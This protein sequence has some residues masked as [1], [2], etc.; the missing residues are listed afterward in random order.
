MWFSF[1][2]SLEIIICILDLI[3]SIL[4]FVLLL[5]CI[6]FVCYKSH[7]TLLLHEAGKSISCLSTYL[8]LLMLFI[9]SF[10]P[11]FSNDHYL[12]LFQ[13]YGSAGKHVSLI[14]LKFS[15]FCFHFWWYFKWMWN[16]R[17]TTFN[18]STLRMLFHYLLA[19]IT[20]WKVNQ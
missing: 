3:Q 10:S 19:S 18:F 4:T 2:I 17:L 5:S 15:L 14:F 8:H 20:C 16:S 11:V 9:S 7:K 1:E 6:L 13:Q 12:P